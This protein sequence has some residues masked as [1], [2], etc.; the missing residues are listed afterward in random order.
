MIGGRLGLDALTAGA[1]EA[2]WADTAEREAFA[3]AF[4]A[5]P[6]DWAR[7]TAAVNAH[8]A[9]AAAAQALAGFAVGARPPVGARVRTV[10]EVGGRVVIE[11]GYASIGVGLRLRLPWVD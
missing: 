3:A 1:V 7:I 11:G 4:F 9:A 10:D 6:C 5:A 8:A 2:A